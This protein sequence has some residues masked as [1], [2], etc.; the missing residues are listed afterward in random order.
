MIKNKLGQYFTTNIIL[1][2][3]IFEFIFNE[4]SN[5]LE[6]SFG[7]GD[8]IKYIIEK[9]PNIIFDMYEI[10]DKIELLDKNNKDKIIYCDF[11]QQKI[12]KKYK[13]IIGNPPYIRTKT[14]NLYID[15]VEKC[16]N[17]LEENGELIFIVPTDFLKLTSASKILNIMMNNGTFTHIYHPNDEK[18]FENAN[19]DIIVFRYY[20]NNNIEKITIYNENKLYIIN[21]NGLITFTEDIEK[22]NI[23]FQDYFDIYVGIVSGKEEVYKNNELGNILVLNGENKIDKYIYI[24]EF[25]S[26]NEKINNYLYENKKILMDRKIRKFNEFNWFEWGALRN[27]KNIKNN[28]G[29]DCIYIN[30]LTRKSNISFIGK[31]NYFGGG[32]II[33]IPKIDCN[34]NNINKYINSDLFKN[35]FLYSGRFKI[36]HRQISNSYIPKEY[37]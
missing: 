21:N 34:L 17:L 27:I 3:K 15:F 4:P 30:T 37:L 11:L 31:V 2:K 1:Q 28:L 20:K 32:L 7:R 25:P 10:D 5:I 13:T 26:K 33:L 12:E 23:M 24:E 8:L 22:H 16:Y 14:G 29:K 18:M 9:N 35:N 19:I 6:P 36:G